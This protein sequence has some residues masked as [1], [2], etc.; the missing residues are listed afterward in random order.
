MRKLIICMYLL[1]KKYITFL[2][3]LI[4]Y[5]IACDVA[6]CICL[7]YVIIN[8][9]RDWIVTVTFNEKLYLEKALYKHGTVNDPHH[10]RKNIM[11][12]VQGPINITLRALKH[13][14][15]I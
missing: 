1:C 14:I 7:N 15:F 9:I 13:F 3:F 4:I 10:N 8:F 2:T 5:Q 12:R 11:Q 6:Y